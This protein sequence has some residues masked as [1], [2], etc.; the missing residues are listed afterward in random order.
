MRNT[1]LMLLGTVAVMTV[2]ACASHPTTLPPGE[3]S[4]TERSVNADG[5]EVKKTTDTSV[6]YDRDG[7]KR[8]V[9]ETETSKDPKGLFNKST[10]TKTK[11][12]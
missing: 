6:Y 3:Y 2:S 10:S 12:Y 9:Q 11:A 7:N 8:A 1:T 5:T 4:R